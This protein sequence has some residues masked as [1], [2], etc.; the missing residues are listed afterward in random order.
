MKH[1]KVLTLAALLVG[2]I[3]TSLISQDKAELVYPEPGKTPSAEDAKVYIIGLKDGKTVPKTFTVRFGLK[4]MGVAP[5]GIYL[6]D[7]KPTGHHHLIIDEKVPD[8][9]LPFPMSD[10]YKHFG[11]GQTEVTLTLEPGEHTLQLVLGDH[12]HMVH[13]PPVMSKVVKIVVEDK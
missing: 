5:A 8:P 3:A 10:N 2:G 9:K 12:I 4:G 13:N 7:E 11:G 1:L 6:G